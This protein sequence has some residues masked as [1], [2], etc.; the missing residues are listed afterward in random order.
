MEIGSPMEVSPESGAPES[1]SIPAQGNDHP[2]EDSDSSPL[3]LDSVDKF[4]FQGHEYTPEELNR[5]MLRMND[6]TKKTQEIS[7]EKKYFENL[8][9]DLEHIRGNPHLADQFKKIYPPKFHRYVDLILQNQESGKDED[10]SGNNVERMLPKS[11]I[12]KLKKLDQMED[13]LAEIMNKTQ[14][15]ETAYFEKQVD[16]IFAK[17]SDKY[18][19]AVED[20]VLNQAQ[21][22]LDANDGNPRFKL[23]EAAWERIFKGVNDKYQKHFE[24][25]YRSQIESQVK[26]SEKASDSGPGGSAPGR[27]P[28]GPRTF[29]EATEMAIQDLKAKGAR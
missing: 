20:T 13:K 2:K 21:A 27:G 28:S 15:Q 1:N 17:F 18:P 23:T 25:K 4:V 19:Y 8:P 12:D 22:L 7:A 5:A 6:Y 9:A 3:T 14:S 29:A 26:K 11:V 10:D 16:S 24:T